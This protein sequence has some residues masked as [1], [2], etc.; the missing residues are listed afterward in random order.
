MT[1]QRTAAAALAAVLIAAFTT[2]STSAA[3]S[4]SASGSGSAATCTASYLPLPAGLPG[5][6]VTAAD[7]VGGYAGYGYVVKS[8]WSYSARALRWSNGQV[9]DLGQL[10]GA[11]SD[12]VVTGVNRHGTVVGWAAGPKAF[13]S[14]NGRLEALPLPAGATG[15]RAEGINDSGDVVGSAQSVPPDT[16]P[17]PVYTPVLWPANGSAPVKLTGLPSAGQAKATAIDQDGTV[18]VEHYPTRE[19]SYGATALYLWKSG[20]ARKLVNPPDTTTVRGNGLANGRV[21]GETY[22]ASGY[23]GKGVLWDQNGTPSRPATSADLSS[24]NRSG[25]AVGW[26]E[27]TAG[28]YAVWQLNTVTARL[29]AKPSVEVSAD[30]GTIGGRSVVGSASYPSPTLWRCG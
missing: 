18:L 8:G 14:N 11:G 16:A 3:P 19:K 5:G 1:L 29:T 30:N 4:G 28:S 10:A 27:S 12:V 17:H 13:R 6:S 26:S 22:P 15:A 20:T 9:T 24:I 25:Q 2:P 7:S 21:V 23:D